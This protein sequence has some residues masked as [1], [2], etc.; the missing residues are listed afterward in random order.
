ME[1]VA[2]FVA[3]IVWKIA[4][5]AGLVA[6]GI[7]PVA[8]AFGVDLGFGPVFVTI[9]GLALVFADSKIEMKENA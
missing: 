4:C 3:L 6:W 5:I 1:T 7:V 9:V 2:L 8:D